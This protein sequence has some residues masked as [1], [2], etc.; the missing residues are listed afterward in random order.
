MNPGKLPL[1]SILHLVLA[2]TTFLSEGCLDAVLL[3]EGSVIVSGA[4]LVTTYHLHRHSCKFSDNDTQCFSLV[5]SLKALNESFSMKDIPSINI[6]LHFAANSTVLVSLPLTISQ[7]IP[8][9]TS[10]RS[11]NASDFIAVCISIHC[12]KVLHRIF[13]LT[14]IRNIYHTDNQ[15]VIS[16]SLFLDFHNLEII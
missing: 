14:K 11:G 4:T 7:R 16:L 9:A 3:A 6:L 12:V 13:P 5:P 10:R 2:C 1:G 15:L 8:K